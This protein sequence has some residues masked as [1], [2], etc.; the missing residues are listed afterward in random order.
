MIVC[1]LLFKLFW[2]EHLKYIQMQFS[3][4]SLIVN[5]SVEASFVKEKALDH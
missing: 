5:K 4:V 1:H 2:T 3:N